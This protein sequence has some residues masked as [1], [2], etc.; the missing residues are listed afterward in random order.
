[1]EDSQVTEATGSDITDQHLN[2]LQPL[3]T[4]FSFHLHREIIIY[5]FLLLY[6]YSFYCPCD[7]HYCM[8]SFLL[9]LL[10]C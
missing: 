4:G 9:L 1:M 5:S 2:T 8:L 6:Y 3:H 10:L 7:Y